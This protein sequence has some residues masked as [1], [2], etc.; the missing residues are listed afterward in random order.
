MNSQ[1]QTQSITISSLD[2]ELIFDTNHLFQNYLKL[3]RF[4]EDCLSET[5][6]QISSEI[7]NIPIQSVESHAKFASNYFEL[8]KSQK[9]IIDLIAPIISNFS[10]SQL[11]LFFSVILRTHMLDCAQN[12]DNSCEEFEKYKKYLLNIYHCILQGNQNKKILNCIC[13][14]ITI[15][16]II[17]INGNWTNGLEQLIEAAKSGSENN[18][19]NILMTSLIIS[20]I[21]DIFEKLKK[22]KYQ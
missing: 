12:L 14:S 13:S 22:K 16:I 8:L 5:T 15:L 9:N 21:N 7:M 17:G 10:N 6:I 1:S 3:N 18:L 11:G 2:S 20:N 19:G 4:R